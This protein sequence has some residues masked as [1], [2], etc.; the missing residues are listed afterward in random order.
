VGHLIFFL[1][2]VIDDIVTAHGWVTVS[3][4]FGNEVVVWSKLTKIFQSV[5]LFENISKCLTIEIIL[6][7]LLNK[8]ISKS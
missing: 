7:F 3:D 8:N 5:F 1:N 6:S 2:T 4:Y